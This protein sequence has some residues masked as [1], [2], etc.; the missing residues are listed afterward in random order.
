MRYLLFLG[1]LAGLSL[2]MPG[3]EQAYVLDTGGIRDP[4]ELLLVGVLQGL[5][6]RE[7]PLLYLSHASRQCPGAANTL[8]RFLTSHK[9]INFTTL[10]GL[11]E[12]ITIFRNLRHRDGSPLIRGLVH[13]E[14]DSQRPCLPLIAANFSAQE[15]LLP[16]TSALLSHQTPLFV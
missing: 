2:P 16:V 6:N 11:P 8:A 14:P 7:R 15:D 4:Q 10:A 9:N 3:E 1:L 12:A 5:V 13:Y